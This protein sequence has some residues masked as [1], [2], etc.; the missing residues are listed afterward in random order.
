M[1]LEPIKNRIH[2]EVNVLFASATLDNLAGDTKAY[3]KKIAT[4]A[5]IAE[6]LDI[7]TEMTTVTLSLK[8]E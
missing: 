6:L 5:L 8:A 1:T 2:Q 4:I 3:N 7:E